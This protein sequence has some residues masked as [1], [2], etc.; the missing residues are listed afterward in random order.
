[1]KI[2]ILGTGHVGLSLASN[3]IDENHDITLVSDDDQAL[4]R[5][6]EKLDL[7]TVCGHG[8]F[9]DVLREAGA[10]TADML[11]AVT[12][13][14]E[15]NMVACQVAYSLFS[16]DKKI[17]RI[18]SQH[19][20]IRDELFGS[21]NLP[22]DVFIS[23]EQLVTRFVQQLI[24]H[25]GA[26][27]V[28]DLGDG[29]I[30]LV[31]VKAYYGGVCI[32]KTLSEIHAA[33]AN[34]FFNIIA[35]FRGDR[36][37]S[38][39]EEFTVEVGDEVYFICHEESTHAILAAFRRLEAPYQR[40]I[41]AGGGGI[42]G[43]LAEAIQ[44]DYSVKVIDRD[45]KRCEFIADRLSV[46]VLHGD[47]CDRDL[48]RN[49]NIDSVDV[50]CAVTDDDEDNMIACLQAKRLGVKQVMALISRTAYV[51][52]IQDTSI[53]VAISP[54]QV[55]VGSILPYLRKGDIKQV[56]EL[57]HCQT[58]VMEIKVHGDKKTSHLIGRSLEQISWPKDVSVGAVIRS[59]TLVV[60]D[61]NYVV[62]ESDHLVILLGKRKRLKEVEKLFQV[63]ADFF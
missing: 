24:A 3:L 31:G 35:I 30:K 11:L 50:F 53:N 1:M 8:A 58:D 39:T 40:V 61:D 60:L 12:D 4:S 36:L 34:E 20:L 52:M 18:R 16:I 32:G 47:A 6:A 7:R 28:M 22:I 41:V 44:H 46:T 21:D 48:L 19:Y 57:R 5:I 59:N 2:I 17:A 51:D 15:V 38:L 42:G 37:V 56:Y 14:D 27:K 55:T 63:S 23:P 49:E 29:L 26:L 33:V 54:Q 62:E 10:E 45:L 25:P 9:P 13:I 43:C